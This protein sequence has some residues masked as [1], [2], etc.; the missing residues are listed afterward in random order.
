MTTQTTTKLAELQPFYTIIFTDVKKDLRDDHLRTD[1]GFFK[2]NFHPKA[3]NKISVDDF[4]EV[5]SKVIEQGFEEVC[6]FISNRWVLRHLD[7]YN[8][9][10]ARLK[11]VSDKFFEIT[12]LEP[13]FAKKLLDDALEQ[14]GPVD[15]YIFAELNDVAFGNELMQELRKMALHARTT[16][17]ST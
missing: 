14:F 1:R 5:Y 12:A 3:L 7:I 6:E 2:R 16:P 17:A 8:F 11:E 4:I 9:F 15:T 10:E 13:V